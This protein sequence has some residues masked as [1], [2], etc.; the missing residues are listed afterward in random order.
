MADKWIQKAGLKKGALHRALGIPEGSKI[1]YGRLVAA[2]R[3]KG[4]LGRMARL[5]MTLGKL[6]K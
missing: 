3:K 4:K 6:K 1:P 5:A 2:A